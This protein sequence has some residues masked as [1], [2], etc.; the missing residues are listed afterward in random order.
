MELNRHARVDECI[1]LQRESEHAWMVSSRARWR[2][3]KRPR[4]SSSMRV[5]TEG[6]GGF[7]EEE[8][9][10]EE[11]GALEAAP[12][13]FGSLFDTKISLLLQLRLP[14]AL[15]CPHRMSNHRRLPNEHF[16]EKR[17]ADK[18]GGAREHLETLILN[19]T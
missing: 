1:H 8:V 19:R 10:G 2:A 17:S 6:G 16:A 5:P 14:W 18:F 7:L 15:A 9:E 13:F 4:G 3:W 11:S 12:I